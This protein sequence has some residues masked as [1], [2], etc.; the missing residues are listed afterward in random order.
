MA[1]NKQILSIAE[2]TRM[3]SPIIQ[4]PD[5]EGSGKINIQ[6]RKPRLLDMAKQG[7]IPNH[8]LS[9]ANKMVGGQEQKPDLENNEM[10]KQTALMME[11]YCEAC[12]VKPTYKE[13]KN[14]MTDEQGEAIF[15]WAVGGVSDLDR[16][17]EDGSDDTNDI[18]GEKV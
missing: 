6:V 15:N 3:A 16:F 11:L 13:F 12:M 14:I 7:K 2:L 4:I 18:D 1:D 10:L 5:F 9:V 17:R 8:L